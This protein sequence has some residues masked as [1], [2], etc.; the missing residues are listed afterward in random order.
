M[1]VYVHYLQNVET[2]IKTVNILIYIISSNSG[3]SYPTI[4]GPQQF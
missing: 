2:T 4:Q 3:L 1:R